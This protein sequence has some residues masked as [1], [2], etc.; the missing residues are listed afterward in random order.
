MQFMETPVFPRAVFD[1]YFKDH[2]YEPA[3]DTFVLLDA[4]E[5]DL[6]LIRSI[7]YEY[8]K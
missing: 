6:N 7:K 4:I 2:V 5:Q 3:E 1:Y 8:N